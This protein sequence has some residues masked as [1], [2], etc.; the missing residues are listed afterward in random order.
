MICLD[1]RGILPSFWGQNLKIGEILTST[2]YDWI[3]QYPSSLLQLDEVPLL[4]KGP[5]FAWDQFS[6]ELGRIFQSP[7]L[8]V[9]GSD[10]QWRTAEKITEGMGEHFTPLY[11]NVS[12]L[13][14]TVCWL[15]NEADVRHIMSL[16]LNED[17]EATH[18]LDK[19]FVEGFYQFL[20]LETLQALSKNE[21]GKTLSPKP[22]S[23]K[24]LPN[25]ESLTSDVTILLKGKTF[26]GR[27]VLSPDFRRAWKE[28]YSNRQLGISGPVSEKV[29]VTL[30][31]EG[32]KTTMKRS[33]WSKVQPGDFVIL[34]HCTLDPDSEKGRIMVTL[35][36]LPLFRAKVKD[37]NVKLLEHPLYSE[38][39]AMAHG[40]ADSDFDDEEYGDAELDSQVDDEFSDEEQQAPKPAQVA[41]A[42]PPNVAGA[43]MHTAAGKPLS[44]ED[45]P[46][47]M[48]VEAGRIEISVQK[49]LELQPGNVL[50]LNIR[51]ED[52]VDLVVNGRRIAKGELIRLGETLGV[53]ILDIG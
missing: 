18:H 36:G 47:T 8:Q 41:P 23:R 39:T 5:A 15:L 31:L 29:Q 50:E 4:G 12:G 48:I 45:I 44:A 27:L 21:L 53:R 19:D 17:D 51:P 33:E 16:L 10:F 2:T 1:R 46:L 25:E 20:V 34:D 24:E 35:N 52:G 11:F 40:P 26:V 22:L 37:G 43:K 9:Q 32:G 38:E 42:T 7:D 28:K 6:V 30:R 14:G 49:L 13:N 3:K